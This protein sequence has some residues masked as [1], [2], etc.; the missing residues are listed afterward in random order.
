MT[1]DTPLQTY[2]DISTEAALAGGAVLQQY[3]GKL[4][5]IQEKRPGDLVTEADQAAE[6]AVLEVIGRHF[7]QHQILA[8]ESG[9]QGNQDSPYLW[10]ID[11]LDGTTNY[12]HQYP[13]S[14]TSIALL[15]NGVPEVGVVFDPFHQ[16][17]FRAATGL[18]ATR[19]RHPIQVSQ[20]PSLANSLLVT[21]FAYD[22]RE[23]TDNNYAEFCHLTH[24][25]QGVRR[26]G[27]ASIDLA[28][29][30]CGRLDGYWERGLSTWDIAAGIVLVKEAGGRVTAYDQ[31]PQQLA[32]GRLLATNGH[33]HTALS[34]ELM[35]VQPLNWSPPQ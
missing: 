21:G 15:I 12:A 31:S 16:E 5:N 25:T 27:S 33:I 30:A 13:F 6:Q 29:I 9:H 20:T 8:E 35:Q 19:N 32:S 1:I 10:A 3:W 4:N 22:R 28:Y 23:T 26:G 17:L 18:G 2:L 7:P 11:P 34:Q 24:L 14:A